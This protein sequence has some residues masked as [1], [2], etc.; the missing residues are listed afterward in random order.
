[1]IFGGKIRRGFKD[2]GYWVLSTVLTK[3]NKE[4]QLQVLQYKKG[5]KSNVSKTPFPSTLRLPSKKIATGLCSVKRAFTLWENNKKLFAPVSNLG[6]LTK[7]AGLAEAAAQL[8]AQLYDSLGA[9]RE[10]S[11][12]TIDICVH[13][14]G[15]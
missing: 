11:P 15:K 14:F 5:K 6:S 10:L 9:Q 7:M 8:R 2:T 12:Q 4:L 13:T 1:M 3:G